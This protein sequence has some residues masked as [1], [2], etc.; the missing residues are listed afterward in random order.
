MVNW[1]IYELPRIYHNKPY[2]IFED[3]VE[4]VEKLKDFVSGKNPTWCLYL[5]GEP[6]CG[7]THLVCH[8]LKYFIENSSYHSARF[9]T[10]RSFFQKLQD[11]F[12]DNV[13]MHELLRKHRETDLLIFDDFGAMDETN[14]KVSATN[15]LIYDRY[16]DG[17]KTIITSNRSLEDY[18]K[19][20]KNDR[21]YGRIIEGMVGQWTRS[22]YLKPTEPS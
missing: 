16:D 3:Q 6:R 7:K 9:L 8:L 5:Y 18:K 19:D 10:H 2:E 4:K 22:K 21:V 1:A 12:G 20:T 14:W 11:C 13:A 17:R 15:D